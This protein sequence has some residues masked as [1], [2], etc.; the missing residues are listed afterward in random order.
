MVFILP[1]LRQKHL[2]EDKESETEHFDVF[3]YIAVRY[4]LRVLGLRAELYHK[5]DSDPIHAKLILAAL[6]KRTD[7]PDSDY[8]DEPLERMEIHMMTQLMKV[9]ASRRATNATKL[10][11][12]GRVVGPANHN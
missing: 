9:A 1:H 8:L 2:N 11:S 7:F 5:A 4:A 12:G 6:E 10:V 3:A